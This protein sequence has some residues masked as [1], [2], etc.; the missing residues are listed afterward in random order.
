MANKDKKYYEIT[1]ERPSGFLGLLLVG[2]SAGAVFLFLFTI[3][4]CAYDGV[5]LDNLI[6]YFLLAGFAGF[7]MGGFLTWLIIQYF[8]ELISSKPLETTTNHNS[9][10]EVE[11]PPINNAS[12]VADNDE[13]KGKSVDYIFPEFSPENQ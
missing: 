1:K 4:I 9:S 2:A 12:P 13:T 3:L 11:Q 10:N 5:G 6:F 7:F 8:S